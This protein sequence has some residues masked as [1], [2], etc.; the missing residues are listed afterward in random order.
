[1][2][3]SNLQQLNLEVETLV[4]TSLIEYFQVGKGTLS[5][6]IPSKQS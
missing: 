1:M 6:H 5:P 4:T 2:V 3:G